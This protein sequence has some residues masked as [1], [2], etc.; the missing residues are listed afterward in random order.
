MRLGR[1]VIRMQHV[2]VITNWCEKVLPGLPILP[3]EIIL[4]AC[5]PVV[6][7]INMNIKF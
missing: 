4:K 5:G 1:K 7:N 2:L 6:K 3:V